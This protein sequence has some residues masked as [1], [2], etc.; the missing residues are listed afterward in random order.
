MSWMLDGAYENW[1][2]SGDPD[3][4]LGFVITTGAGSSTVDLDV[5]PDAVWTGAGAEV[6][7]FVIVD[8]D[9][10]Y[11]YITGL[12]IDTF[13]CRFRFQIP[14]GHALNVASR[15]AAISAQYNAAFANILGIFYLFNSAGTLGLYY[16]PYKTTLGT[17]SGLEFVGTISDDTV[18]DVQLNRDS[19]GAGNG[20][21]EVWLDHSSAL[22]GTLQTSSADADVDIFIV[23]SIS[24]THSFTLQ[25][26]R[27]GYNANRQV[28][29]APLSGSRVMAP[30]A[31]R[32]VMGSGMVV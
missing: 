6:A 17:S 7:E 3:D 9:F 2:P 28:K 19:S 1:E 14:T 25:N 32:M 27:I 21:F 30:F 5:A 13:F 10:A 8:T 31:S 24:S 11:A 12:A 4:R 29:K 18:Y 22:T 20:S 26:D 15:F 23:G 16:D